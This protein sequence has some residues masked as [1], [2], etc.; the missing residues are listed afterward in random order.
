M[1]KKTKTK[2]DNSDISKDLLEMLGGDEQLETVVEKEMMQDNKKTIV[3]IYLS[4]MLPPPI[5]SDKLT[6][7]D[8]D[9]GNIGITQVKSILKTDD[10]FKITSLQDWECIVMKGSVKFYTEE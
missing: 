8:V 9:K 5:Y 7:K 10:G 2:T 4:F 6:V 1:T 3:T